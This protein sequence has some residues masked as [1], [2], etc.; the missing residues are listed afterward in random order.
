MRRYLEARRRTLAE[1]PRL[2]REFL[3]KLASTLAGR[4]SI[5]VFGGRAIAG[6]D[7][8]EPRDLDLLIVVRDDDD[9]ASVEELAYRLKPREL[10]ADIIVARLSEL[11]CGIAR[12]MLRSAVLVSDPL[13]VR[14]LLD[15]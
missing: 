5:I 2:I 10:P 9:P 12:L 4:A 6:L 13:G 8:N 7:S 14:R 11:Q 15:G 3:E 1:R